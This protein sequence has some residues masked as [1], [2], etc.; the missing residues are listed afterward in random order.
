MDKELYLLSFVADLLRSC[1]SILG[2]KNSEIWKTLGS[3]KASSYVQ[4]NKSFE[5]FVLQKRRWSLSLA[6][7]PDNFALRSQNY[8]W[9]SFENFVAQNFIL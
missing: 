1:V 9:R 5:H 4:K 3:Y 2:K 7:R 8:A 6:F